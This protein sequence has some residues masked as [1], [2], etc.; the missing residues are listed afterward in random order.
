MEG[1]AI[2]KDEF[3]PEGGDQLLEGSSQTVSRDFTWPGPEVVELDQ[4]GKRDKMLGDSDREH[5]V[6]PEII[7][8]RNTMI[9]DRK[10]LVEIKQANVVAGAGNDVDQRDMKQESMVLSYF[11]EIQPPPESIVPRYFK[12]IKETMSEIQKPPGKTV[13]KG[14][15]ITAECTLCGLTYNYYGNPPMDRFLQH[16][17]GKHHVDKSKTQISGVNLQRMRANEEYILTRRPNAKPSVVWDYFVKSDYEIKPGYTVNVDC[18][19]CDWS[20]LHSYKGS[21]GAMLNHLHATHKHM[22]LP[23]TCRKCDPPCNL[24]ENYAQ[25]YS[26]IL[27]SP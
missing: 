23:L 18:L 12:T 14:L 5:S 21:T 3:E 25:R 24:R 11:T 2:I 15:V 27:T 16:L 1:E 7:D 4:G 26:G 13:G 20:T 17:C 9:K 19:L 10:D 8:I 6:R 22:F